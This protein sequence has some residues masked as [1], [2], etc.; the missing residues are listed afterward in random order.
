MVVVA[1]ELMNA[2]LDGAFDRAAFAR[3][4]PVDVPTRSIWYDK[5]AIAVARSYMENRADFDT[6]DGAVNGLWSSMIKDAVDMN[7]D[8]L[9]GIAHEIYDA[10]D[11]GEWNPNQE[12]LVSRPLLKRIL[13]APATEARFEA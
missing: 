11:A 1:R 10:F 6:A 8:E 3:L 4:A 5:L 9:P 13:A 2:A 12:H 7:F